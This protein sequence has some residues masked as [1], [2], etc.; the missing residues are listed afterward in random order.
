MRLTF[1]GAG[2]NAAVEI[3]LEE[4][5]HDHQGKA[6]DNDR[7][8]FEQL[9]QL[10]ALRGTLHIGD[11]AGF[12]LA[13]DQDRAEDQ[14][15][16]L[17][18]RVIEVDHGVEVAVPHTHEVPHGDGG[19]DGGTDGQQDLEEVVHLRRA[20]DVS[21]FL[22]VPGNAL[23][24]CTGNNHIPDVERAGNHD[25]QRAVQPAEVVDQ[26]V[27][28]DQTAAKEHR[29]QKDDVKEAFSAEVRPGH[30]V[31]RQQRDHAAQNGSHNGVDQR[32][33]KA[34]PDLSVA[35]HALIRRQGPLAEV[36][37]HALVLEGNGVNEG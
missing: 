8:V 6:G 14:L 9:S 5:I 22:Q 36:E 3:L 25:C 13:L 27:G 7:C 34:H 2:H 21:R 29:D 19:D 16:G 20:V 26:Q 18:G 1:D 37:S 4:G 32:V 17:L 11:H 15:Q 33:F 31:G 23:V 35:H 24:V 10:G 30:G 12:R 28:R